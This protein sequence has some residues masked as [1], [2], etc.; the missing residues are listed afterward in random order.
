MNP[1]RTAIR[2]TGPTGPVRPTRT[3]RRLG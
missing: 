2:L 1:T 3:P